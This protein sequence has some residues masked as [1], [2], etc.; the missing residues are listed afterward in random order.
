[1]RGDEKKA[2]GTADVLK[3]KIQKAA[4]ELTG[5]QDLKARGQANKARGVAK[6]AGGRIQNAIDELKS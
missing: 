6:K 4:G 5:N 2:A 1:M 3:G